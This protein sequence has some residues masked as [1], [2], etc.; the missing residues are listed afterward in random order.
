MAP[1]P[2][3]RHC[4]HCGGQHTAQVIESRTTGISRR[5]RYSCSNCGHRFTTHEIEQ[6]L[7]ERLQSD[8]LMLQR[9]RATLAITTE[10]INSTAIPCERCKHN[11]G[12][13]CDLTIP[14]AFTVDAIGCSYADTTAATTP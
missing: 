11:T 4:H 9:I 3:A 10:A 6:D 5:R 14:E 7:F 12:E 2:K 8:S 13:G 1:Q